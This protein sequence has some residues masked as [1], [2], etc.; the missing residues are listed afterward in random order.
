[1]NFCNNGTVA[2]NSSKGPAN[3]NNADNDPLRGPCVSAPGLAP[4]PCRVDDTLGFVVALS[5]PDTGVPD[6]TASIG[7]RVAADAQRQ[8]LGYAGLPATLQ[9]G[10]RAVNMNT[11]TPTPAN[12]RTGFYPLARRLFLNRGDL[13][14]STLGPGSPDPTSEQLKFMAWATATNG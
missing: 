6:V 9:I 4:T 5:E 3:I 10:A 2:P 13:D 14:A 8:T 1:S 12:I 11:R 7:R